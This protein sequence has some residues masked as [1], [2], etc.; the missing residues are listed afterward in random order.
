MTTLPFF[1]DFFVIGAPRCGTTALCRSLGRH[2]QICFSSPKEPHYFSKVAPT[3]GC[4][5]D[6]IRRDYL[7]RC[8]AAYD[9]TKHR[10][11]G[12]GSVTYL[13]Y[14]EAIDSILSWNPDA[15]FIVMLRNPLEM[16]PS[17]H[18]RLLYLME[19]DVPNFA[20]AWSLQ[21]ARSRGEQL[22]NR[23]LEPDTLRYAEIGRH[24]SH[25]QQLFE[26]VERER[27]HVI[28]YDDL[29][30]SLQ[31]VYERCLQFIGVEQDG[32]GQFSSPRA[33]RAY[34][35]NWVQQLVFRPPRDIL[36]Y[37]KAVEGRAQVRRKSA[38]GR[39]EKSALWR[40]RQRIKD[41]NSV[42]VPSGN[43]S[44]GMRRALCE[45]FEADVAR[46]SKLLDRDFSHWLR[47]N[48]GG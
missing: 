37:A 6:D 27:C 34:R 23:C 12:E 44:P 41:W 18:Q 28:I 36:R 17:L 3:V 26:K 7:D 2:R 47:P 40:L 20:K 46:L 45:A 13:Y 14:P 8:F 19:E 48:D 43:L 15:L 4:S 42:E 38:G 31:R 21:E 39:A 22:P 16:V 30:E 10:A 29:R 35:S 24:A 33:S 32:R 25:L 9:P 1:P 5:A 11:V